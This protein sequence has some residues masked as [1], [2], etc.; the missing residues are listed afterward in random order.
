[1]Y[2]IRSYYEFVFSRVQHHC[3]QKTSKGY[4]PF[5]SCRVKQRGKVKKTGTRLNVCKAHFPKTKV[6]V[7]K[8]LLVCRGLAKR[9]GLSVKGRFNQMGNLISKRSCAWQSGTHPAFAVL[10][11]SNSH[12]LPNNRA[13][14]MESTHEDDECKNKACKESCRESG[15]LQKL[16]KLA[17]RVCRECTG[18]HSGY[19]FKKQP[20]YNFV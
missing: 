15:T 12:T 17:Q 19:T 2:A 10:F 3:H 20:S 6:L 16:A 13:P 9:H 14:L 8:S 4:V 11:R 18:Y 1:M 5:K 7:S